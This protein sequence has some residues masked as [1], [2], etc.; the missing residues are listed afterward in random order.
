MN[1]RNLLL[2]GGAALTAVAAGGAVTAWSMG[3]RDDMAARAR[4]LRRP[5]DPDGGMAEV[6]RYATLA[7]NGHNTQPWRF[8]AEDGVLRILSDPTR[9][10]PVVD[11]DDHH[12]FIGMGAAAENA[13]LALRAMGLGGEIVPG[14]RDIALATDPG[15][16]EAHALFH[17]IPARQ[18][19]RTLFDG[20][21]L[22][23]A[24][25]ARMET[26]AALPGVRVVV[27][28]D[29]ARRARLREMILD[30]N[31][32]QL[33]DPAFVAELKHWMRFNPRAAM[34]RG[35]GLYSEC[36]GGPV[37]PDWVG[38]GLF[39]LAL[40]PASEAKRYAA[41]IDSAAGFAIFL[42]ERAEPE[43]WMRVGRA[44]QR[45]ALQATALGIR[46]SFLNQP[47][48]VAGLR[49]DLAA[50]AGEDLRPDLVMRFGHGPLAPYALRR[51]VGDVLA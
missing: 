51:P 8:A 24:Q 48:E 16:A 46:H 12:L 14:A 26:A 7:P 13:A 25:I 32:R 19:T 36:S 9:R 44:S 43:H 21:A 3:S 29:P 45:F 49:A 40:D 5:L 31:M 4:A 22:A 11:P 35:D 47:V 23:P 2:G 17:A 33:R 39:S 10:T 37:V 28:T 42:A 41:Q 18:S 15:L 20:R 27:V 6:V 30:G 50:L 1:R 34:A 38:R